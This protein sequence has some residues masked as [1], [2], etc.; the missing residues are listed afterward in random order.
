MKKA[1]VLLICIIFLAGCSSKVKEAETIDSYT[2]KEE[3]VF[4]LTVEAETGVNTYSLFKMMDEDKDDTY[5]IGVPLEEITEDIEND[6]A[7]IYCINYETAKR[8]DSKL[9][10]ISVNAMN[11]IYMVHNG[12]KFESVRQFS[13]KKIYLLD[14]RTDRKLLETAVKY[15]SIEEE[16][17]IEYLDSYEEIYDRIM[18]EEDVVAIIQQP[19]ISFLEHRNENI[20]IVMDLTDL[21]QKANNQSNIVTDCIAVDRT[22]YEEKKDMID[23]YIGVLYSYSNYVY[24]NP[25]QYLELIKKYDSSNY[26][27]DMEKE[28]SSFGFAFLKDNI[29]DEAV[30]LFEKELE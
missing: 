6:R 14:R 13:D 2:E 23:K 20:Q 11:N 9:K 27:E 17:D 10:I 25:E 15:Y 29:L 7:D 1:F 3:I 26:I 5:K 22:V 12:L 4:D 16:L 24:K 18:T 28:L 8:Y 19:Y 30:S 21:W